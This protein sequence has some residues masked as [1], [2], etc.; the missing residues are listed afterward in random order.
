MKDRDFFITGQSYGGRYE[1]AFASAIIDYNLNATEE[2]I[3]L[4]GVLIGNGYVDTLA[5]R[6]TAR[7][8]TLALG[9]IQF[10]SIPQLETLERRCQDANSKKAFDAA[11]TCHILADFITAVDGGIDVDDARYPETNLTEQEQNLEKYLNQPSVVK[12][13]HCESSTKQ[14]K[15]SVSNRTVYD[16]YMPDALK[17]Y[18]DDHQ[19]ILD[20]D[21]TLLIY[22]GNFD[23]IDG[24]YGIQEWMK[25]LKW[26]GMKDFYASSRNVYYYVSD[27]EGEV[28]LGGNF[29][30]Y[31]N[32]Q[33][34]MVYASGHLVPTTQLAL[35]R[36]MLSDIIYH[37]E[38]LC[39]LDNGTCNVDQ[40]T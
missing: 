34:L 32:L 1:P 10:D 39:H 25:N 9:S 16:N 2:K 17:V 12:A 28:R 8:L 40:Q 7:H 19:K 23:K 37:N 3:P 26:E 35:T 21:I 30:S 15:Y 13:L 11:K 4:K 27:D 20:N 24:P 5:Q 36:N 38:L 6:L 14:T 33:V 22:A 29:K 18:I 31:K